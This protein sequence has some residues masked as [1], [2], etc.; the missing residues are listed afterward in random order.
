MVSRPR[1]ACCRI[2]PFV[3]IATALQATLAEGGIDAEILTGN[4]DQV[5]GN[6]R[7]RTFDM[8]VGRGGDRTGAHPYTSLLSIVYNPDNSDEAK[9]YTLQA[10][11]TSFQDEQINALLDAALLEPDPEKQDEMYAAIQRKFEEDIPAMQ[12]ISMSYDTVVYQDDIEGYIAHPYQ[13]TRYREVRK[14]R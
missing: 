14:D 2:S 5:Y 12:I 3:N 7:A 10:W 6:M 13:N 11:R 4:G 8:I 1:S 9:L